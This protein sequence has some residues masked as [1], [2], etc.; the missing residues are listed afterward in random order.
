VPP[1]AIAAV[2]RSAS[3]PGLGASP[4]AGEPTTAKRGPREAAGAGI[5]KSRPALQGANPPSKGAV[6]PGGA[7]QHAMASAG[8]G[9]SHVAPGA[10]APS[11]RR[12]TEEAEA[13]ITEAEAA[14]SGGHNAEARIWATRAV[15]A[16]KRAP[17]ELRV[18]A[19]IVMGKVELASE[20]YSE[21]K[22]WFDSALAIDPKD[23]A[24]LRGRQRAREAAASAHAQKP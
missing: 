3:K 2:D 16:A 15:A 18:R 1:P 11:P 21:A 5:P 4:P 19:F 20:K 8:A 7:R 9:G 6:P 24:A 22:R 14:W 12:T 23:L 17:A 13:A 10:G